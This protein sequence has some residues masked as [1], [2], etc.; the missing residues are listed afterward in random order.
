MNIDLDF[1]TPQGQEE[2]AE[3]MKVRFIVKVDDYG[4]PCTPMHP[5]AALCTLHLLMHCLM[6]PI[7]PVT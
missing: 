3:A 1:G 7:S 4:A 6:H 2:A 5:R